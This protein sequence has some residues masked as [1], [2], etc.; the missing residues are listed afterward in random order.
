[1]LHYIKMEE[2]PLPIILLV[3]LAQKREKRPVVANDNTYL[4]KL[5]Y[6]KAELCQYLDTDICTSN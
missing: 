1:M 2:L 6:G 5:A 4:E 3:L